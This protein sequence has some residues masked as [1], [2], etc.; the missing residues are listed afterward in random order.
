MPGPMGAPVPPLPMLGVA[1]P[2]LGPRL[3]D[4]QALTDLRQGIEKLLDAAEKD[5]MVGR[6]LNPIIMMLMEASKKL[7]QPPKPSREEA[8]AGD[9]EPLD[10]TPMGDIGGIPLPALLPRL[11]GLGMR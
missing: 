2:P 3:P 4:P 9:M 1:P 10:R 8:D 7:R 6:A 5:P 11:A